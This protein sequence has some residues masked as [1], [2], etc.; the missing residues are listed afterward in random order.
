MRDLATILR[1]ALTGTQA[2][3]ISI[4]ARLAQFAMVRHRVGPIVGAVAARDGL[5]VST[6]AAEMFRI[7]ADANK[8]VRAR[9]KVLT[10]RVAGAFAAAGIPMLFFKGQSVADRLYPVPGWRDVRDA[11]VLVPPASLGPATRALER[12]GFALSDPLFALPGFVQPAMMRAIRDL[13][14]HDP[15]A[16]HLFEVH[17]R[18]LFSRGL[19]ARLLADDPSLRPRPLASGGALPVPDIGPGFAHYLLLHGCVSGWSRLKWMADLVPLFAKLDDAGRRQL[20]EFAQGAGTAAAVK[21]SLILAREAFGELAL[22]PLENWIDEDAGTAAVQTRLKTYAAWL[23]APMAG[24]SPLNSRMA[25]LKSAQFLH[26]GRLAQLWLLPS[27]GVSA[28]FR[29]LGKWSK[30]YASPRA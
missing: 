2:P 7:D 21:A 22:G 23:N 25:S 17:S 26:D 20:A 28:A 8:D 24:G 13:H 14:F 4:D 29:T 3:A 27:G 12:V 16:D 30:R 5:S 11:D 15:A 18:L 9:M 6:E 1:A 10:M 19:S